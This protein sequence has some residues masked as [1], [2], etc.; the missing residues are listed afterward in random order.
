MSVFPAKPIMAGSFR[1]S[2]WLFH[3]L[4]I[5]KIFGPLTEEQDMLMA[6]R[7]AIL[8]ALGHPIEF[9]PYYVTTERPAIRL[10]G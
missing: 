9:I 10:E 4:L 1:F 5:P 3:G 6:V 2:R 8:D 7:G